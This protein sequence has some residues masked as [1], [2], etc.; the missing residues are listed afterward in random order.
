MKIF[1]KTETG[2]ILTLKVASSDTI[3][4]VKFTIQDKEGIPL[5]QQTL[6]FASKQL[7]G[8]ILSD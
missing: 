6:V 4:N 2:K 1:V 8:Q 7:E 5:N 3:E